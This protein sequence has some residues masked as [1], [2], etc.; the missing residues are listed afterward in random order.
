MSIHTEGAQDPLNP[1]EAQWGPAN[2]ATDLVG[3]AAVCAEPTPPR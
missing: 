2:A 3:T 1:P